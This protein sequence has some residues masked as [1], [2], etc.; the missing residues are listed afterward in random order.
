MTTITTERAIP[1]LPGGGSWTFDKAKWTWVSNDPVP[2]EEE[3]PAPAADT[4]TTK[5]EQE[6]LP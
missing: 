4:M 1:P 3:S 6:Q 2:P 5:T